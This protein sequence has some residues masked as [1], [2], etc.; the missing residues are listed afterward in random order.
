MIKFIR[1]NLQQY[2]VLLIL[3]FG[4]CLT[5]AGI[6][7]TIAQRQASK[8]NIPDNADFVTT[9]Q[10]VPFYVVLGIDLLDLALDFLATPITWVFLDQM[11]LKALRNVSAIEAVIPGT[12]VIPTLT[13]AWIAVNVFGVRF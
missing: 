12:Q 5:L 8:I 9:L 1:D 13:F 3:I 2:G 6:L 11:G 4:V 10:N 7:L